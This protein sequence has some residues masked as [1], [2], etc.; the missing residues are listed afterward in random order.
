MPPTS[1][2]QIIPQE[3][4][5]RYCRPNKLSLSLPSPGTLEQT[6]RVVCESVYTVC[7]C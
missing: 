5:E 7:V 3:I 6:R 1:G 2:M 4:K